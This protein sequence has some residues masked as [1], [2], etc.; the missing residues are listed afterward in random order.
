MSQDF[1]KDSKI[2]RKD[3]NEISFEK[4]QEKRQFEERRKAA[5]FN[6]LNSEMQKKQKEV[7][8]KL[9]MSP[10]EML[11]NIKLLREMGIVQDLGAS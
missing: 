3:D 4:L 6:K 9:N 1:K 5:E 8:A 11:I 10:S 7:Q 2:L